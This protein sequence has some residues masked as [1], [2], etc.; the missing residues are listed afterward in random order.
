MTSP[1]TELFASIT[2]GNGD[3][4]G[5]GLP[6][7]DKVEPVCRNL[8]MTLIDMLIANISINPLDIV[9]EKDHVLTASN[10]L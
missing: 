6:V 7:L 2:L 8:G 3:V 1:L 5:K 4:I 9:G 10:F